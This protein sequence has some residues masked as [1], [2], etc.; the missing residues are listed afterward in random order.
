[1]NRR[2]FLQSSIAAAAGLAVA[3]VTLSAPAADVTATSIAMSNVPTIS[4]ALLRTPT[5]MEYDLG[6][7]M[8]LVRE[9]IRYKALK[10]GG[11]GN[12]VIK[13]YGE[14]VRHEQ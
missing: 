7:R 1:M 10:D 5:I 4:E 3:P 6:Y 11:S 9:M 14:R 8:Q 12:V 13:T 2:Q